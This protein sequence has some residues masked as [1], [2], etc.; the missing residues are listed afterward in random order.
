MKKVLLSLASA[1]LLSWAAPARA[2]STVELTTEQLVDAADIIV[3]GTVAEV[4]SEL[5]DDG[6][7]Q[8]RAQVEVGEVLKGDP[9]A[10]TLVVEQPGGSYAGRT[11]VVPGTARFSPGEEVVLFLQESHGDI[12]LV[13]LRQ[14]KFTVRLDP[15][16]RE[17]VVVRF[18][19]PADRP[20]DHRFV[21]LPPP[22]RRVSLDEL[23][24]RVRD[25]VAAGWDGQPIPGISIERLERVN[26]KEVR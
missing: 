15:S 13:G 11:M 21:P 4:W 8:T 24:A 5:E 25:R 14:G 12:G 23:E 22:D 6:L 9:G 26:G 2:T 10:A 7:I 18:A 17:P 3:H 1:G 19:P 16:T 20:Y